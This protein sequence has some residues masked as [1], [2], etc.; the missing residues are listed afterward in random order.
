MKD[1]QLSEKQKELESKENDMRALNSKLQSLQ[2]ELDKMKS[3]NNLLKQTKD[4][5]MLEVDRQKTEKSAALSKIQALEKAQVKS[6]GNL[7]V[8]ENKPA[9]DSPVDKKDIINVQNDILADSSKLGKGKDESKDVQR[10]N[11]N[12]V[13]ISGVNDS[14]I[15]KEVIKKEENDNILSSFI[16]KKESDTQLSFK[17]DQ[18][19]DK[20]LD[21]IIEQKVEASKDNNESFHGVNE[22]VVIGRK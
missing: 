12:N 7:L 4:S 15:L 9:A 18:K 10:Q 11:D 13:E 5:L 14:I 17:S 3:E 8:N 2:L 16:E 21:D 1:S 19:A 22:S 6:N 20:S